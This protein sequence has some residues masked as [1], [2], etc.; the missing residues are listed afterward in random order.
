MEQKLYTSINEFKKAMQEDQQIN[1]LFGFGN[2]IKNAFSKA[3]GGNISKID[4]A[5]N[6]YK[7]EYEKL[8]KEKQSVLNELE[9]DDANEIKNRLNKLDKTLDKKKELIV[10]KLKND[11]KGVVKN[12]R[13]QT[14]LDVQE[15]AIKLEL[16]NKEIKML[17]TLETPGEM[18][19]RLTK[20]KTDTTNK[21]KEYTKK[22]KTLSKEEKSEDGNKELKV[23]E[24]VKYK[25]KDGGDTE[26]ELVSINDD[27]ITIKTKKG[28][29][30]DIP[31]DRIL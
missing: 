1:E 24:P 25:L 3:I 9:S 14:Y 17:S 18:S 8:L 27:T 12:D 22:L 11:L 26:N 10:N 13:E 21:V 31:K 15:N 20:L 16:I 19:D 6:T 29:E 28:K 7:D 5:L 2:K 4:K 30:F 23:G